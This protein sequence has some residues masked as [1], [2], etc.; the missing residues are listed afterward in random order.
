MRVRILRSV[1]VVAVCCVWAAAVQAQTVL[2]LTLAHNASK[3]TSRAEAIGSFA[4]A[5]KKRSGG[6]ILIDVNPGAVIQE[7]R[8]VLLDMRSGR[9]DMSSFPQ[10]RLAGAVPEV[11][12]LGLPFAFM[13]AKKVWDILEGPIGEEL[14]EKIES[15]G[16]IV[17]AWMTN[18][19]RHIT[20]SK[21][22]ITRPEDL[23]G[24][25]IRTTGD[26]ATIDM[27]V[28]LGAQVVP[29]G[30]SY[31]DDALRI[32]YVD[33]QENSLSVIHLRKMHDVQKFIAVTN[34][35]YSFSPLLISRVTWTRLSS[36]D[37]KMVRAAAQEAALLQRKLFDESEERILDEYRKMASITVT[38][39]DATLFR[40]AVEKVWDSWE[41]KPFGSFVRKLRAASIR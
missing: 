12:A 8:D 22:P 3:G 39:P 21:K 9:L 30:Y 20:N 14:G 10:G 15:N 5:V 6:R 27:M 40:A 24:L 19:A 18:G 36:D 11:D 33:G 1:S 13:S 37:R 32:R 7:D 41:L 28:A 31:L 16:M 4:D 2:N 35:N 23:R 26:K 25:R 34:H 29:I 17:L 38:T